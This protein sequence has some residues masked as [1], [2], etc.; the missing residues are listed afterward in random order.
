MRNGTSEYVKQLQ[1]YLYYISLKNSAIPQ[2]A[3]DGIYGNETAAAVSAYQKFR[4]LPVTGIVDQVTFDAISYDYAAVTEE[5]CRPASLCIFPR[6]GYKAAKGDS[7]DIIYLIQLVLRYIS[8]EYETEHV[9][10]DGVYGDSEVKAVTAVQQKHGL[11][12][13]GEVDR[14]TWD[15]MA[16]DCNVFCD[17]HEY[18]GQ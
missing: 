10:L 4:G 5:A 7:D 9:E 14:A 3:A 8:S 2:T 12:P 18:N 6:G 13:T 1:T 16:A 15:V 11:P 17:L